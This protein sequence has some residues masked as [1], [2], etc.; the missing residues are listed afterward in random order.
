MADG[1]FPED[2]SWE[3][4]FKV[5]RVENQQVIGA[6]VDFRDRRWCRATLES[7]PARVFIEAGLALGDCFRLAPI[8]HGLNPFDYSVNNLGLHSGNEDLIDEMNRAV[9]SGIFRVRSQ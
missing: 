9:D 2:Y 3:G 6:Y 7:L 8:P 4:Y 1:Y 5:L